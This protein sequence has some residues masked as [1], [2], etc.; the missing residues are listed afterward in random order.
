MEMDEQS[1]TYLWLNDG[2]LANDEYINDEYIIDG[3]F[4]LA[5]K[6]FEF[7]EDVSKCNRKKLSGKS[8][9]HV[10]AYLIGRLAK[11]ETAGEW[12]R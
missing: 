1:V 5:I 2:R 6:S 12:C 4:I 3:Y 8:D 9:A 7:R 11:S 10:P